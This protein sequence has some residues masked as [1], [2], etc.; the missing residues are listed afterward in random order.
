MSDDLVALRHLVERYA[1]AADDSD[2]AAAAATFADDG[3]LTIHMNRDSTEPT[4]VRRGR[5]EIAAAID[6]LARYDATHHVVSYHVAAVDGD[7]ATG[8]ARCIAHHVRNGID[9]VLYIHYRDTY[10]RD[11]GQWLIAAR[12]LQVE[13]TDDRPLSGARP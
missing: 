12:T 8:E 10:V 11:D 13:F 3:V 7:N 1:A 5:A 9:H 6:S 4:S 2:G